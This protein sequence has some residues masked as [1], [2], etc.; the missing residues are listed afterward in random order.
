MKKILIVG[1]ILASAWSIEYCYNHH[2]HKETEERLAKIMYE[3]TSSEVYGAIFGTITSQ[4]FKELCFKRNFPFYMIYEDCSQEKIRVY[5]NALLCNPTKDKCFVFYTVDDL[6]YTCR[7][8][9][10]HNIFVFLANLVKK[11]NK[12]EIN[13]FVPIDGFSKD[14]IIEMDRGI[15]SSEYDEVFKNL[16]SN[17]K[18]REYMQ[19]YGIE[20]FAKYLANPKTSNDI[21]YDIGKIDKFVRQKYWFDKK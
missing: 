5:P 10:Q 19:K 21:E 16:T 1:I 20:F 14:T 15:I 11:D 9:D 8:Y 13:K 17:Q 18:K 2:Y 12:W 7:Y 4:E 6:D 3:S